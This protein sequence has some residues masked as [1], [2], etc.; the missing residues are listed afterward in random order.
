M[1]SATCV[2]DSDEPVSF[3]WKKNNQ[4]LIEQ[5]P[6]I[7]I[8]TIN[9]LSTLAMDLVTEADSANYTCLVKSPSEVRLHTAELMVAS[10]PKWLTEPN[11]V[12]LRDINKEVIVNC[13]ATGS[14]A[15]R[16]TWEVNS[17][18]GK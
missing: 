2:A 1:A 11:D 17:I 18:S 6:R 14:P 7:T 4:I 15:P 9:K 3:I 16:I 8:Y 12:V 10:S 5:K 13:K